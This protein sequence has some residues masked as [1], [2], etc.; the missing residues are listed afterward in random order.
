MSN[1]ELTVMC[2]YCGTHVS[3]PGIDIDDDSNSMKISHGC[4]RVCF[5]REVMA[6]GLATEEEKAEYRSLVS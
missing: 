6:A 2:A 3:G 4:C 5:L 1:D